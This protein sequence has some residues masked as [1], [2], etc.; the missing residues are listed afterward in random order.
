MNLPYMLGTMFTGSRDR[1]KVVGFAVHFL[2]GWIFAS[3]YAAAFENWRR[4]T[5][6]LGAA[7]GLV[8]ALFVLLPGMEL[9]PSLHPRMASEQ[10]G[11]TRTRQL[12]PPGVLALNYGYRTPV[13]VVLSHIAYGVILGVFYRT[14]DEREHKD[15]PIADLRW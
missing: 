4:S 14:P 11:P 10:T 12:E 9:L 2:N 6:W 15:F 1:A 7:I 13:S 5:W 8:H 3:V